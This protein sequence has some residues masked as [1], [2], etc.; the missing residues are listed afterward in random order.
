MGARPAPSAFCGVGGGR[1]CLCGRAQ[2]HK[3]GEKG[4]SGHAAWRRAARERTT[5]KNA[6]KHQHTCAR[7][8][9]RGPSAPKDDIMLIM[10]SSQ[11]G[12][13]TKVP[14][15]TVVVVITGRWRGRA[16]THETHTH[17]RARTHLQTQ[18]AARRRRTRKE[19]KA[20]AAAH[21][22]PSTPPAHLHKVDALCEL[23]PA[24]QAPPP[25]TQR[26]PPAQSRRALPAPPRGPRACRG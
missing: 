7:R 10:I 22:A 1:V 8:P 24:G 4:G 5:Q 14:R 9:L 20:W 21:L 11:G 3:G 18:H 12:V 16:H 23:L 19:G 2:A 15:R 6:A 25:H 13:P 26:H 17:T